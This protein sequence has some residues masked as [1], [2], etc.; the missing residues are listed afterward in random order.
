MSINKRLFA[1]SSSFAGPFVATFRYTGNSSA[2]VTVSGMSFQPDFVTVRKTS[3][4]SKEYFMDAISGENRWFTMVDSSQSSGSNQVIQFNSD[5]FTIKANGDTSSATNKNGA[6]YIGWAMYAGNETV[7]NNDGNTAGTQRVSADG[8]FSI[9]EFTSGGESTT[10]GHGLGDTPKVVVFR[11]SNG[12]YYTTITDTVQH[13]EQRKGEG[14]LQME[15]D[16]S[17]VNFGKNTSVIDMDGTDLGGNNGETYKMFCFSQRPHQQF[18]MWLGNGSSS[19]RTLY[20][21]TDDAKPKFARV[22]LVGQGSANGNIIFQQLGSA[23]GSTFE[24]TSPLNLRTNSDAQTSINL[25]GGK[26]ILDQSSSERL[27]FSGSSTFYYNSPVSG[28]YYMAWIWGGD[29]TEVNS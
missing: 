19:I 21:M 15:Q 8:G 17:A 13:N 5:G 1:G 3:E 18:A 20:S 29:N 12:K 2:D 24:F 23:S 16:Q 9:T 7:T 14:F 28:Y 25:A 26:A 11:R 4:T 22:Q 27:R 10:V 6:S